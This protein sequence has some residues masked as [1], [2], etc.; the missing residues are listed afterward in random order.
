LLFPGSKTSD[1]DQL[2]GP[3]TAEFLFRLYG[4]SESVKNTEAQTTEFINRFSEAWTRGGHQDAPTMEG[5]RTMMEDFD[6]RLI[7]VWHRPRSAG[8]HAVRITSVP[9]V[10][11]PF[12][13]T[14]DGARPL[15]VMCVGLW[16]LVFEFLLGMLTYA[17]DPPGSDRG[18][19]FAK[20]ALSA[21]VNSEPALS[22]RAPEI[23]QL[24]VLDLQ[25]TATAVGMATGALTWAYFHEVTHIERRHVRSGSRV[26]R[27]A[28]EPGVELTVPSYQHGMELEADRGGLDGVLEL[29]SEEIEIR[30]TVE[31]GPMVDHAASILF[32]IMDIAYRLHPESDR[33]ISPTH[34]SPAARAHHLREYGSSRFSSEGMDFYEYWRDLLN[35]AG[36]TSRQT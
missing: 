12:V 17:D 16:S 35:F 25:N 31:F 15:I 27:S 21:W 14:R 5:V 3:Q 24:S 22:P 4:L 11:N 8:V 36:L 33:R 6:E 23:Q 34:P 26:L 30:K 9:G 1:K 32:D 19:A 7:T 10:S 28:A 18:L 29:M 20:R 13:I 2:V